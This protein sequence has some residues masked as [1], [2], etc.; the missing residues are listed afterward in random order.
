MTRELVSGDKLKTAA[1]TTLYRP[2]DPWELA[3]IQGYGFREFPARLPD[4]PFFYPVCSLEY[5]TMIA[6]EWTLA[7]WGEGYVTRFQVRADYLRR[8]ESHAVGG[9][10]CREYWIPAEEL[11]EFNRNIVGQIE[12]VAEYHWPEKTSGTVG[13]RNYGVVIT[14]VQTR[15]P[16]ISR[17]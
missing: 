16:R 1:T 8:Y 10:K 9:R 15:R 14:F 6:Q 17:R 11:P 7:D 4:Q 5:A 3:L 2:V 12:V 13:T